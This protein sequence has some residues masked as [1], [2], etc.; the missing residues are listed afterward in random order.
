MRVA[1]VSACVR[2]SVEENV[3]A[4]RCRCRRAPSVQDKSVFRARAATHWASAC[5][6]CCQVE[7]RCRQIPHNLGPLPLRSQGE[8]KEARRRAV[9]DLLGERV[10]Q[11]SALTGEGVTDVPVLPKLK[12]SLR[13]SGGEEPKAEREA[14]P[15]WVH[16][17]GDKTSR[18]VQRKEE[19][20]RRGLEEAQV[21]VL[22]RSR[23]QAEAA[24]QVRGWPRRRRGRAARVG[25][26][27]SS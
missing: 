4:R 27:R 12:A 6:F 14:V 13:G 22:C 9:D 8:I 7:K 1:R 16:R 26:L 18:M 23:A 21:T 24:V 17:G 11:P 15:E 2:G 10:D 20:V 25:F 19:W 3:C 5:V